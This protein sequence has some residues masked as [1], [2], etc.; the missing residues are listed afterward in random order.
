M[1]E[2]KKLVASVVNRPPT[3]ELI[4]LTAKSLTDIRASPEGIEGM[5]AFLEKRKPSWLQ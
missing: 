2:A 5:T 3:D 1:V 4:E